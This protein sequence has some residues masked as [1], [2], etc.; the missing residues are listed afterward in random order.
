MRIGVCVGDEADLVAGRRGVHAAFELFSAACSLPYVRMLSALDGIRRAGCRGAREESPRR[1]N[2]VASM[3]LYAVSLLAG[4]G[5]FTASQKVR[6]RASEAFVETGAQAFGELR[7]AGRH[8]DRVAAQGAYLV[9]GYR[10]GAIVFISDAEPHVGARGHAT[11][12]DAC[13]R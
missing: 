6:V 8:R 5:T 4:V 7:E 13:R 3:S 11:A 9:Y 2:P 12:D 10:P 1:W